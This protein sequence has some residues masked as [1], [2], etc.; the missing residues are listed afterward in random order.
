MAKLPEE[1]RKIIE[2]NK[3][4]YDRLCAIDRGIKLPQSLKGSALLPLLDDLTQSEAQTEAVPRRVIPWKTISTIAAAFTL[5]IG[6]SAVL[7]RGLTDTDQSIIDPLAD[8]QPI[9]Q[10]VSEAE[11]DGALNEPTIPDSDAILPPAESPTPTSPEAETIPDEVWESELG[12]GGQ[13]QSVTIGADSLYTYLYHTNDPTDPAKSGYPLTVSIIH[14]ASGARAFTIDIPEMTAITDFFVYEDALALIGTSADSVIL[15]AY[16]LYLVGEAR[17]MGSV[18]Q[19]GT[20]AGMHQ[21]GNIIYLFS[22][23]QQC[24]DGLTATAMPNGTGDSFCIATAIDLTTMVQETFAFSGVDSS[25]QAQCYQQ[26]ALL[27]SSAG[28][29]GGFALNGMEISLVW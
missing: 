17:L 18:N 26:E 13:G 24:P 14:N 8:Q 2:E 11:Q 5:V 15:D 28:N 9:V 1:P 16:D 19:P 12:T 10:T 23:T 4:L 6:L 3:D 7:A 29:Q 22:C 21:V 25:I 20:L 27:A